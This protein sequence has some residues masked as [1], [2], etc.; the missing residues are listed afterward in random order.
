MMALLDSPRRPRIVPPHAC[1]NRHEEISQWSTERI[2]FNFR[3]DVHP[4]RAP[5]VANQFRR[6]TSADKKL[7]RPRA[8]VLLK[9]PFWRFSSGKALKLN[10]HPVVKRFLRF[11]KRF[12]CDRLAEISASQ[13]KEHAN[14]PGTNE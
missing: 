10:P 7:Q 13:E 11:R 2:L 1:Q 14:R 3:Q 4:F 12:L 8:K 9:R 5:T 6:C